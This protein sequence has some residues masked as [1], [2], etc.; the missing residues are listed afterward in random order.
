MMRQK[1]FWSEAISVDLTLL[2]TA[3]AAPIPSN[4]LLNKIHS[5]K[6]AFYF[7]DNFY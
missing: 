7:G 3:F 6:Q 2:F 4:L 5:R 1:G